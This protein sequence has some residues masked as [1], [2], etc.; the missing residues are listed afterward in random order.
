MQCID[1]QCKSVIKAKI[2]KDLKVIMTKYKFNRFSCISVTVQVGL[3][4][5]TSRERFLTDLVLESD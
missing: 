2:P 5:G 1:K 3:S 4:Q